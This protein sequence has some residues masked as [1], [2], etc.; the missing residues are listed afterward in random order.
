MKNLHNA[1]RLKQLYQLK[2]LGYKYTNIKP[3]SYAD[4]NPLELPNSLKTLKEQAKNCHL[5]SLSKSRT[6]VVFGE[7]N[8]KA[9]VMFIGDVPLAM[10]DN[11]GQPF[12][13][14]GG[15]MLTAMIEKVLG[16]SRSDVYVTNL[17]K[18]HPLNTQEVHETQVHTCKAY[19]FKEMELIQA[20]IVVTLGEKAY[21]Y[22]TNDFTD[23]KEVRGTIIQNNSYVLV[24]TY[25]PNFLLKNPSLK[26]EVFMD[27]QK[28]KELL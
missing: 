11:T 7:G 27:L 21:H 22:V 6:N 15:E 26:K 4:Q 17:L 28:I 5:C 19:L 8:E 18:C 24:P 16:L 23:L 1:L 20:K 13:G 14:R 25:H 12:L 9:T 3:F 2:D 10:E